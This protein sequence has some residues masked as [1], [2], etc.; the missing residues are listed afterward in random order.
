M[1]GADFLV[2]V[3]ADLPERADGRIGCRANHN[4]SNGNLER[5]EVPQT[6]FLGLSI[7]CF[8]T[9]ALNKERSL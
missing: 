1:L 7:K 3:G 9:R 4:W 5:E 2:D 6:G 8:R